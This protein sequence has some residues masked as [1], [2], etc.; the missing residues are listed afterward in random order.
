MWDVK[1]VSMWNNWT[2]EWHKVDFQSYSCF[3]P[4]LGGVNKIKLD[5]KMIIKPQILVFDTVQMLC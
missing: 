5:V 1:S 2:E 3:T 4:L